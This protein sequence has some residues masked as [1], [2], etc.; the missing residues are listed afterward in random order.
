MLDAEK[1]WQRTL[2]R[3]AHVSEPDLVSA[4]FPTVAALA[5]AW[6][7]DEGEMCD[8]LAT[9]NDSAKNAPMFRDGPIWQYLV[10][11]CN[12]GTQHRTEAAMILTYYGASPCDLDFSWFLRGWHDD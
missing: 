7:A 6:R 10:H 9:L 11:V 3:G 5:N 2:K 1:S 8:W 4:S 12:H